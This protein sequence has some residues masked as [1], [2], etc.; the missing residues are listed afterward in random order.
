MKYAKSWAAVGARAR[1]ARLAAN[2]S[3]TDLAGRLGLDRSALARVESGQRQLTALELFSLADA[4]RLPPAHFMSTTPES[5]V[6][7]RQDLTE[8][9]DEAS[10]HRFRLDSA[11][12][13]HARDTAWLG[14]HGH[15]PQAEALLPDPASWSGQGAND[16]HAREAARLAR[17]ALGLTGPL[18]GMADV[19]ASAGLHLLVTEGFQSCASMTLGDRMGAAVIGGA[20]DPGRRRATAAH[21]LGHFV[22]QDEYQTDIGVAATR[23]E[24]EQRIDAFAIE[25]LLPQANLRAGWES[26]TELTARARLVVLAAEYRVSWTVAVRSAQQLQLIDKSAARQ[27][28]TA[29]PGRGE[30]I[31]LMGHEPVEDLVVGETSGTWRQAVFRAWRAADI[32]ASRA[33]ELLHG[34]LD[35]EDLPNRDEAQVW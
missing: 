33:A 31:E 26:K 23:D 25:F 14:E 34:L 6:S 35:E 16:N 15:L 19:C 4:L 7:R 9:S 32:T 8:D 21:E 1:E 29:A 30:F 17:G 24:R 3:Q 13:E 12:E 22:L 2:M 10:R 5:V 11:L 27:I 20:A 18:G 28:I